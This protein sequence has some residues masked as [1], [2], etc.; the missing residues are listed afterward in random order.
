MPLVNPVEFVNEP[1][2]F[3]F[4]V[5]REAWLQMGLSFSPNVGALFVSQTLLREEQSSSEVYYLSQKFPGGNARNINLKRL[6]AYENLQSNDDP[7]ILATLLGLARGTFA[8]LTIFAMAYVVWPYTMLCTTENETQRMSFP[9]QVRSALSHAQRPPGICEPDNIFTRHTDLQHAAELI[10]LINKVSMVGVLC[11][12]LQ[13][14]DAELFIIIGE[15]DRRTMT[16][17]RLYALKPQKSGPIATVANYVYCWQQQRNGY[18]RTLA[19]WTPSKCGGGFITT[20]A[21]G[22][23]G[24]E[25]EIF[26]LSL[27][28]AIWL[29]SQL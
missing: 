14:L 12:T 6:F 25:K 8:M 9:V 11:C 5:Q 7:G 24:S 20:C 1:E 15:I 3:Q 29:M 17:A 28:N 27:R 2:S 16:V 13:G 21:S 23:A 26:R 19:T 4:E 22:L 10:D 18:P